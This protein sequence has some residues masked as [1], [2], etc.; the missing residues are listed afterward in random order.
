MILWIAFRMENYQILNFANVA[1]YSVAILGLMLI[2]GYSGQISI[3]QSF[4]FGLGAYAT[5]YFG[6]NHNW[7]FLLTLPVSAALG[8]AIGFIVGIPALRIRGL[9]PGARDARAR[10]GVPRDR[11]VPGAP[12]HHRRCE[13]QARGRHHLE[14]PGLDA[15]QPVESGL[16]VPRAQ[17]GRRG[18]VPP[19]LEHD[20]EPSGAIGHCA[21]RQ[22]GRRGGQRRVARWME[23]GCIRHQ[24]GVRR[25]RRFDARLRRCASPRPRPVG[26]ATAIA[27]LTGAVIGGLGTISGSVIGA[28]VV[29]FVPYF[30]SDF[31]SGGG[32]LFIPSSSA[33]RH[34][35]FFS[36]GDGPILAGALYG[37]LLIAVV[38]VMPGGIAYFVRL[39]RSKLIRFVPKLPDVSTA[40]GDEPTP[41][42][43]CARGSDPSAPGGRTHMRRATLVRARKRGPCADVRGRGL[44]RRQRLQHGDHGC[45]ERG[46]RRQLRPRPPPPAGAATTAAGS[47]AASFKV[48]TTGCPSDVST[49][50]ADG[51]DIV[52][53][54]TVPLTGALAAFGAIPQGMNAV[55]AK[56]NEAGGIDGHKVT[57]VAKDDAYDPTK[58]PP[59]A[60]ELV[61]KDHVLASVFQVG[62]PNVAATQKIFEDACTPQLFV[63]TGF[64]NWGD[65]AHHPWTIGGIMAYNSEA[66]MWGEFIAKQ[67]PGAKIAELTF[68][69]D[70]GK[71]YSTTMTQVAKDKGFTIVDSELHEG[72]D[73]SIDNQITKILASNPDV[74]LG[75]T[76]GA[77]LPEADGRAR[78]RR[79]TRAS[80][81]SPTRARRWHRSSSRSIRPATASTSFCS[82][83]TRAT[84]SMQTIRQS[85]QY[86]ADIAKYG[87][88]G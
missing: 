7:N 6:V 84:R 77:V 57:L 11:E 83:R 48:P 25:G 71:V 70:F 81:S 50:L 47:A 38:F 27:L 46:D 59:L 4:F 51:A 8:F 21:P 35:W 78:G 61:E 82:R 58:T 20:E 42:E 40:R 64:P 85:S 73:T 63:A 76:T 24:R 15:R 69:N 55:F 54:M 72:T 67:K 68:D 62:T 79:A 43:P 53:G 31:M 3:G 2:I 41:A 44:R 9:L 80:R 87:G 56:V 30:T 12:R 88:R 22:R 45:S 28:L 34:F 75:E 13:R 33:P 49:P 14:E 36:E 5:A 60:T 26:S 19:R 29:T 74:V 52:L 1:A 86:K 18:H 10:R 17:R 66:V 32:L 65:P 23:G 16:A 37:V 39:M